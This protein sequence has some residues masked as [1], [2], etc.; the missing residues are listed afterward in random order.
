MGTSGGLRL[1]TTSLP[2]ATPNYHYCASD[3]SETED[4]WVMFRMHSGSKLIEV[5][6]DRLWRKKKGSLMSLTLLL[7]RMIIASFTL[8]IVL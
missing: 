1:T 5:E 3:A 8:G 2:R 4:G 6:A 7:F